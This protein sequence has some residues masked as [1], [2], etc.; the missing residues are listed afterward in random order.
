MRDRLP[1]DWRTDLRDRHALEAEVRNELAA[2]PELGMLQ[3]STSS[4]ERLDY[5][6]LGPG[7]RL[8]EVELKAKRQSYRGWERYRPEV[9]ERDLLILDE[10]ALR[11]L[12]DAGRYAFLL[13]RDIPGGRWAV[14]STHDLVMTS[15]KRVSRH[16]AVGTGALKGKVLVSFAEDAHLFTGLGEAVDFIVETSREIDRRWRDIAPWPSPPR[17]C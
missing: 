13:V 5:Q 15:K 9:P 3:C 14:W 12:V 2:H 8:L 6:L 16:L 10:L 11:K 4:T 7:A 17:A 1:E